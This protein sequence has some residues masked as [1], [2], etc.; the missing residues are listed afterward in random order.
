[1]I[2]FSGIQAFVDSIDTAGLD[3]SPA[4]IEKLQQIRSFVQQ[5]QGAELIFICTHNSRRS[6]FGQVWA[7]VMADCYGWG[8]VKTFSGGTE[9]TAFNPH[10]IAALR[11]IGFEIETVQGGKNPRYAVRYAS[12]QLPLQAWS[13]V[14]S[15]PANPQTGFCAVMTCSE[16]DEACPVVLGAAERVALPYE[17]PKKS[18]GTPQ[19]AETYAMRCRQIAAEM[20]WVFERKA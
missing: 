7:Q 6:H 13:K 2:L 3:L 18:D 11:N 16:A 5:N 15:D 10:A 12:A 17:D 19:Q 4:R 20:K 8:G 9:A 1:M 14:Y